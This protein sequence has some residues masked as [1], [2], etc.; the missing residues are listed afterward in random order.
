MKTKRFNQIVGTG[1]I[2]TGILFELEGDRPLSRNETR[3]ARLSPT[4]DYCKQHIIL[5]YIARILA[6]D[7]QVYPIGMV[8]C[9]SAGD[10]L[11]EQMRQAGMD[12]RFVN[13]T[14]L[15]PTM[16]CVCMQYPD[17]AVCNVTTS[18][19]ACSLVNRSYIES[20]LDAL[21]RPLG[22]DTLIVSVPEV[23]LE[24]RLALLKR[25]KA[26][27]AYCVSSCLVDEF[28]DFIAGGGMQ[29]TDLLVINE[30]E[31]AAFCGC[32]S[33]NME[34]RARQCQAALLRENPKARLVMTCGAQGSYVCEEKWIA[35][36]PARATN[37][38]S[39]GGAGDAYTAGVICGLAMGLDFMPGEKDVSAPEL[40]AALS[41]EAIS[42]TD[43]IAEHISR[44]TALQYLKMESE[45]SINDEKR[46][47]L[48]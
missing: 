8:G 6:P 1:G 17:K 25:G 30:D 29:C 5:H 37:V 20:A 24:A 35:H 36:L 13:Q 16:Y 40:G 28:A 45:R 48:G 10:T 42:V 4:R 27:R 21:T 18:E 32:R 14:A 19:S 44:D 38:V 34:L 26:A 3:L 22:A 9:D 12:V 41:A 31:A 15:K 43:T 7:V 47:S 39:T 23:P 46:V 2:G 33:E 11:L